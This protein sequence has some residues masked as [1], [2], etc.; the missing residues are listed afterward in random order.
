MS[1]ESR[2][3]TSDDCGNWM[4]CHASLVLCALSC[5]LE[6]A[7]PPIATTATT[8][9]MT[10]D[11]VRDDRSASRCFTKGLRWVWEWYP[12]TGVVLCRTIGRGGWNCKLLRQARILHVD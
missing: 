5:A 1:V 10:I 4:I 9:T 3:N 11:R 6:R 2:A 8:A 12:E 7:A